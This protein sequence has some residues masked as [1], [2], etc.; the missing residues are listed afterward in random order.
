MKG[1]GK[2]THSSISSLEHA[3]LL[4]SAFVLL[5]RHDSLENILGDIPQ[6]GV[7]L[8]QQDDYACGLGVE[9]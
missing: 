8:L 2:W 9:G 3:Q 5:S 1:R 4:L 6:L 7:L